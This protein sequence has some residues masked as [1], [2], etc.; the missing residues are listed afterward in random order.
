MGNDQRRLAVLIDAENIQ[1]SIIEKLLGEVAH[2]GI[3]MLKRIYGDWT[4]PLNKTWK[5]SLLQH[6][7][8][9]IQQ[10]SYTTGKNATDSALIIDAMDILY[11]HRFDGFC[12]VSS[13]SDFTRLA[14]RLREEGISV[15]GFGEQKTP[16]AFVASCDKFIDIEQ[17]CAKPTPLVVLPP[18]PCN[19]K[20]APVKTQVPQ[21]PAIPQKAQIPLTTLR[22]A[23]EHSA[24]DSGWAH[25]GQVGDY[26]SKNVPDFLTRT[27]GFSKLSDV[28][29]SY[30][31]HF[32]VENRPPSGTT[33]VR[34][35]QA[36][37]P[38]EPSE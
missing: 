28:L 24:D 3:A 15:F 10:F 1:P 5:Q 13:D 34:L 36:K 18:V 20:P 8:T 29:K 17:W 37:A 27:Y 12:I 19:E 30:P 38:K 7:L 33:C 2:Y 16:Q 31:K 25:L 22:Q 21:T 4:S 23:V 6:S 35:V 11:T 26:L 32:K 9:P 14:Q